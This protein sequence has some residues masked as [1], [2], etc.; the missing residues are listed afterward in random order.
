VVA[1][2][3]ELLSLSHLPSY[4]RNKSDLFLRHVN[5]DT[6]GGRQTRLR[7]S[8]VQCN[9]RIGWTKDDAFPDLLL[10]RSFDIIWQ[11]LHC[12]TQCHRL[13]FR[14]QSRRLLIEPNVVCHR[15]C[16]CCSLYYTLHL[17]STKGQER[18][19][20]GMTF[21]KRMFDYW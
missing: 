17:G 11:W 20:K 21:L 13:R 12:S 15:D 2:V 18:P 5:W 6:A 1:V 8:T 16:H 14:L 9:A 3:N 19:T 4:F 10:L 7:I